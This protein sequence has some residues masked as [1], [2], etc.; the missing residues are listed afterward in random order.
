MKTF[1]QSDMNWDEV[2]RQEGDMATRLSSEDVQDVGGGI[3]WP[4]PFF[5]CDYWS[6]WCPSEP[7]P[8]RY[9]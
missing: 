3:L 2:V 9:A 5:F 8:P 6:W 7:Q 4:L 1:R